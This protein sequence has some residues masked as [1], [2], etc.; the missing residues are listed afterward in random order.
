V[1]PVNQAASQVVR[2]NK[3]SLDSRSSS[4]DP[5]RVARRNSSRVNRGEPDRKADPDKPDRANL[6][7]N[8]DCLASRSNS[9]N[10]VL[11]ARH[12]SKVNKAEP[13]RKAAP[14]KPDKA[15]PDKANLD[16]ANRDCRASRSNSASKV[17]VARRSSKVAEPGRARASL[18]PDKASRV[19]Q[20]DRA[21]KSSSASRVLAASP[22]S[23]AQAAL[24]NKACLDSKA[25]RS[26]VAQEACPVRLVSRS[27]SAAGKAP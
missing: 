8:R 2:V 16:K 15:K 23:A 27:N 11:A 6:D 20:V 3:V 10:K 13:D 7:S 4:V 22:S 1:Q 19:G 12:C 14:D 25:F 18:A 17:L 21:S 24:A 26:K 9:A 5:A